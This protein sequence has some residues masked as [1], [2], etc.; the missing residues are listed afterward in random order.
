MKQ[1]YIYNAKLVRVVDGDTIVCDIDLGFY[2]TA[3][4]P[5]RLAHI[6]APE[7][8]AAGG[9]AATNHLKAL[10]GNGNLVLKT[11]KPHDKYGRYLAEVFWAENNVNALMVLGGHAVAYE[12]GER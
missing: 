3:R 9:T 10:L 4:M 11:F 7:H 6:N 2:M 8:N 5:V 12:G 1:D